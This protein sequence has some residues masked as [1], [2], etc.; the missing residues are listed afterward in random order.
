[1]LTVSL[2]NARF[3]AFHGWY[4]HERKCGNW[5]ELDIDVQLPT[6]LT[7][8]SLDSTL[9]YAVLYDFAKKRMSVSTKLLE[10]I[11]GKLM[12]DITEIASE[13]KITIV[14]RKENPPLGGQVQFSQIRLVND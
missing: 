14:I 9:D 6:S 5:F 12:A 3:F 10:T 11:A 4:E 7:E 13:A 2:V 8:D 1:M